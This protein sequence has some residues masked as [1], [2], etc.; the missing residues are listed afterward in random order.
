MK[1]SELIKGNVDICLY[2]KKSEKGIV[3]VALFVIDNLM[4]GKVKAIDETTTALKENWL[5]LKIVKGL[6][7]YL[8]CEVKFAMDK[9]RAWLRQSHLNENLDKKMAVVVKIFEAI[10]LQVCLNF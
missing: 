2:V 8:S 5:I 1:E 6:Q 10:K 7:N 4:K 3:Y 9:K